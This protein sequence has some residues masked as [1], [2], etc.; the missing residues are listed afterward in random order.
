MSS[1]LDILVLVGISHQREREMVLGN[2]KKNTPA[3][4]NTFFNSPLC[5]TAKTRS[6]TTN[7]T[8]NENDE[9]DD[10][11]K[12]FPFKPSPNNASKPETKKRKSVVKEEDVIITTERKKKKRKFEEFTSADDERHEDTVVFPFVANASSSLKKRKKKTKSDAS[13]EQ[14]RVEDD[15]ARPSDPP[16]NGVGFAKGGNAKEQTI[17]KMVFDASKTT[18]TDF[19]E[20]KKPTTTTKKYKNFSKGNNNN[21]IGSKKKPPPFAAASSFN[22][23]AAVAKKKAQIEVSA[24]KAQEVGF[25]SSARKPAAAYSGIVSSNSASKKGVGSSVS[26]AKKERGKRSSG[27]SGASFEVHQKQQQHQPNEQ[28]PNEFQKMIQKARENLRESSKKGSRSPQPAAAAVH[29]RPVFVA[30]QNS[31]K[32][33]RFASP[34]SIPKSKTNITT[35]PKFPINQTFVSAAQA[36]NQN[37]NNS[38]QEEHHHHPNN[39]NNNNIVDIVA[40]AK[41]KTYLPSTAEKA[42]KKAKETYEKKRIDAERK[43]KLGQLRELDETLSSKT[44]IILAPKDDEKSEKNKRN[45]Y[46]NNNRVFGGAMTKAQKAHMAATEWE[47]L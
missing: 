27:F 37:K 2:R 20:R 25:G 28:Q 29:H 40:R 34:P 9:N 12:C 45:T 21:K 13:G 7:T 24:K 36:M 16:P 43:E 42:K 32:H 26:A 15:V 19:D 17:E 38:K 14:E 6:N 44:N 33:Q 46:N 41:Q 11:S 8:T 10:F 4:L 31:G 3:D 22:V 5:T 23:A 39:N 1:V 18:F 47:P 35:T 30:A